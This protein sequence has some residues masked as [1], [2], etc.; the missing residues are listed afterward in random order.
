MPPADRPRKP[1]PRNAWSARRT[2]ETPQAPE[3]DRAG[4]NRG[5]LMISSGLMRANHLCISLPAGRSGIALVTPAASL[6][7][8]AVQYDRFSKFSFHHCGLGVFSDCPRI[9]TLSEQ[10]GRGSM[11]QIVKPVQSPRDCKQ[12]R[13]VTPFVASSDPSELIFNPV[14]VNLRAFSFG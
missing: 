6:T 10:E 9:D 2:R 11:T 5:Q 7:F 13:A 12:P 4:R 3:H 14:G 8:F 1:G